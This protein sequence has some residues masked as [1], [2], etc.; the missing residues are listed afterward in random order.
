MY[1]HKYVIIILSIFLAL[2]VQLSAAERFEFEQIHMAVPIRVLLYADSEEV[3]E[4][5]VK[6]AF[7][8]FEKINKIMSDYDRES[9]I[10]KLTLKN[11]ARF[12]D[13]IP[14]SVDDDWYKISDDL[15]DVLKAARHYSEISDG[16]FEV[17]ISPL[18][19][20]WRRAK[21]Q[22]KWPKEEDIATARNLTGL[23]YWDLDDANKKIRLLKKGIRFDLGAI[24]KGYAIDRAFEAIQRGGIK[25]C[26][27]DAGGDMRL[28]DAPPDG[29]RIGIVKTDEQKEPILN[30]KLDNISLAT[31]GDT[32]QYF[33]MGGKRYSHI[34]DPKT[35]LPLTTRCIVTV[36]AKT[37]MEADALASVVSVLGSEKGIEL[38]NALPDVETFIVQ[39]GEELKFYRSANWK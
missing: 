35:G 27:I 18:V 36:K 2:N 16:A 37:A 14:E 38:I 8:Q 11:D 9:E 17:S 13:S 31:S 29:W 34:I 24:A 20:L 19:Q 15:Y 28:G 3:A 39:E 23:K 33:E 6:T 7:E 22:Q 32:F 12:Q 21:R 25:T 10:V 30:L 26:L 4:Q 1:I 5:C